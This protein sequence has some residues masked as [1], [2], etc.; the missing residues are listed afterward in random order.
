MMMIEDVSSHLSIS[1]TTDFVRAI[2][3]TVGIAISESTLLA[4]YESLRELDSIALRSLLWSVHSLTR[5]SPAH[6]IDLR[7]I[8]R[9]E[10]IIPEDAGTNNMVA[11]PAHLGQVKARLD[12]SQ[13]LA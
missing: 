10:C 3:V 12:V 2:A 13:S 4:C 7:S 8:Y 6:G 9:G 1:M 5:Q 11:I